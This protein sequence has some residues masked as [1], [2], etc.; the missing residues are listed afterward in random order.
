MAQGGP[1]AAVDA[2]FALVCPGFWPSLSEQRR[3]A[4]RANATE[5][6]GDLTMP[7][8]EV[9]Q[10]DL[11]RIHVP[12]LAVSGSQSDPLMRAISATLAQQIPGAREVQLKGSGH[13]TYAEKPDEFAAAVLDFASQL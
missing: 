6:F 12:C 8:Y 1:A 13:V 9:S 3:S 4:Y 7:P 11:A 10:A 5:M 2:F